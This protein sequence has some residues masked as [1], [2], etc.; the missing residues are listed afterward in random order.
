MP[1]NM[2]F[3]LLLPHFGEHASWRN[4]LEGSRKAE[5]YGFD[6]VWV[7][8]H[9]IFH[10]HGMEGTDKTIY[11]PFVLMSGIATITKR[12][13]IG[14]AVVIP[15]RH[16]L[17]LGQLFSSLDAM[18]GGG[19]IVAGIGLGNFQQELEAVKLPFDKR[20]EMVKETVQIMRKAWTEPEFS[21]HGEMYSFDHA[22]I[23]P[24]PAGDIPVWYGGGTPASTR[25]AVDYCDGWF[26]GRITFKTFEKRVAKIKQM[27]VEKGR[28][29][30]TLAA[31]PIT[32][33]DRDK[34]TASD[35]VNVKGLLNNANKQKFWVK[36]ESGSFQTVEDLAGS[37]IV[38]SPSEIVEGVEKY[39]E[40]GAE[41]LVFD[42][43]FRYDEWDYSLDLLGR[44]VLP[45]IKDL[46]VKALPRTS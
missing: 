3:G 24:L 9:L 29:I 30:P 11:E 38:G 28:S 16:P 40:L 31:I 6:S 26:P 21:F 25:R 45:R 2:K 37:F 36:P 10:P 14:T 20:P 46:K 22:Y 12:I 8:D 17:Y 27:C 42:L 13:V 32:S 39:R 15:H 41:H 23:V 44:Q 34:Q 5:D 18:T 1:E 33:V 43:R 7:R 4:C 19:R 35:K